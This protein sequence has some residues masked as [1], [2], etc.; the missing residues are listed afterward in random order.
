MAKK[1]K[2][3]LNRTFVK[4]WRKHRGLTQI[5]LSERVGIGQGSLSDLERGTFAYTQP[6]LEAL[7]DAL[8]CKPWDLIWRPPGAEDGLREILAGMDADEQKRALAVVQA[9]KD[10][11]AA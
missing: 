6:M 11:K 10:T 3:K 4:E 5:Q 2:K 9:L 7:A 8:N 1:R